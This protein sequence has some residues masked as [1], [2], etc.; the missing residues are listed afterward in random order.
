M[1]EAAGVT[2]W[3]DIRDRWRRRRGTRAAIAE[4]AGLTVPNLRKLAQ[5]EGWDAADAP[6]EEAATARAAHQLYASLCRRLSAAIDG[7]GGD[8]DAKTAAERADLIKAHSKA[9]FAALDAEARLMRR[10]GRAGAEGERSD[11]DAAP[12]D[13]PAVL[14]LD[15]ARDEFRRRLAELAERA[16]AAPSDPSAQP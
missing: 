15:A 8:E 6:Q 3:A 9:L 10:R 2:D 12:S 1:G 16:A 4:R 14:D 11:H 5:A 7:I 13:R